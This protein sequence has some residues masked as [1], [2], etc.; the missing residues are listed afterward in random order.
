MSLSKEQ[1]EGIMLQY[2]Q[3]RAGHRRTLQE[4]RR[5]VLALIPQ[6]RELEEQVP[7]TA[8][9]SLRARL[10]GGGSAGDPREA[11]G[12]I[13]AQR[14]ALLLR[15][16]FPENYLDPEYDC[17][18]CRDTGLIGTQKCHCFR[19][20]ET[21]LLYDQSHLG[22]LVSEAGFD[23][24]SEEYYSGADLTRFRTARD[25]SLAFV[26]SFPETY[27]NLYFY[28]TVGTGKSFLSACIAGAVLEK[29]HPV[30]YYSAAALFEKLASLS[31]D[32]RHREE[33]QALT[34]EL[35]HCDLL[36]IDDL[37]T[38][39]TNQFV[40]AQLFT[41]INERHLNRKPTIISTNLT[42]EEMQKRYSDR[43]FSRITSNYRLCKLTGKDIRIL[44][45]T[46]QRTR[47]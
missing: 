12:D 26:S 15:N 10:E 24:L 31:F 30:L 4:R 7:R 5:R 47:K 44:K 19:L 3:I 2:A 18:D 23:R 6:M 25:A 9:A 46:A 32:Y 43:V 38:E 8:V 40:S 1:Y 28:G 16:G 37:G 21:E 20:K 11:L 22:T 17:P 39:L 14:R 13:A 34:R 41:C 36:V 42:L 29:G 33:L 27:M 35:Y 45:F